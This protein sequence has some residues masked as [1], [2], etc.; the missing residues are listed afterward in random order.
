M[1]TL[2]LKAFLCF[3][4]LTAVSAFASGPPRIDFKV[5]YEDKEQPPYYMGWTDA[6]PD[7]N[8]GVVVEMVRML[9]TKLPELRVHLVRAPWTR[10]LEGVR[11]NSYDATFNTSYTVDR[12]ET[13]WYPTLDGTHRGE[14]DT[15][16][17]IT[18]MTYFLYVPSGSRLD[19]DGSRFIN[20]KGGIGA[21][22]GYS[23]VRDL[24]KMNVDVHEVAAGARN[25]L[26]MLQSGRFAGAVLQEVTAEGVLEGSA[27]LSG[28]VKRKTPVV[29][30]EY[31]LLLSHAFVE[32]HPLLARKIWQALAEIREEHFEILSAKYAN[33]GPD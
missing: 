18:V 27:E 9:E 25:I 32:K 30:K 11:S 33:S 31:Y 24:K 20:L 1:G 22:L 26:K 29:S 2:L 15:S 23:I 8:P 5:A 13:G 28:I 4:A 3:W 21:Q 7:A 19:W 12:L 14:P 6:V 10:C 17:R 16:K